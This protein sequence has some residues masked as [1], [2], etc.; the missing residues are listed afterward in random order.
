MKGPFIGVGPHVTI[1]LTIKII[2]FMLNF[3]FIL[4]YHI[5]KWIYFSTSIHV[6][7]TRLVCSNW[8]QTWHVS[9]M[10]REID[11]HDYWM[12]EINFTYF[13]FYIQHGI[14]SIYFQHDSDFFFTMEDFIT[15][16]M[17]NFLLHPL[18]ST[19]ID[20]TTLLSNSTRSPLCS[21]H[22][23]MH[24]LCFKFGQQLSRGSG[25]KLSPSFTFQPLFPRMTSS[26]VSSCKAIWGKRWLLGKRFELEIVNSYL[27]LLTSFLQISH[28]C[29]GVQLNDHHSKNDSRMI[30]NM[31]K[32]QNKQHFILNM[33]MSFM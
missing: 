11:F 28:T 14:I 25:A 8:N 22:V 6:E 24:I 7:V 12:D 5:L 30:N 27:W 21:N 1:Q 29:W 19:K 15:M 31:K 9:N 3:P 33:A 17:F 2:I 23:Y 32:T 26:K 16:W 4:F 13:V 10:N 18:D 20:C